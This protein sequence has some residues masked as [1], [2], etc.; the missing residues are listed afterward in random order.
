MGS[1]GTVSLKGIIYAPDSFLPLDLP[2]HS[3]RIIPDTAFGVQ[4]NGLVIVF[5]GLAMQAINRYL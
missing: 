3:Q 1:H 2:Q 5:D 4:G